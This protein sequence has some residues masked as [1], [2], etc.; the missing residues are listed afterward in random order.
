MRSMEDPTESSIAPLDNFILKRFFYS[1]H[2][3]FFKIDMSVLIEKIIS[4]YYKKKHL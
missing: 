3:R 2:I 4:L 1:Q